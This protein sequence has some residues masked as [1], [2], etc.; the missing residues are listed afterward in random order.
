MAD[1]EYY[2][3]PATNTR[4]VESRYRYVASASQTTFAANYAVGYVDVY[5]NGSH[6]DPGV[7][8]TAA[9][10]ASIVL[11]N[12]A[13]AGAS[14]VIVCRRQV[15]I[16]KNNDTMISNAQYTATAAQ[17]VF[18]LTYT[19]GGVFL[20][21][22]NGISVPFTAADGATVVL[23]AGCLAGDVVV[24]SYHS[25][26]SVANVIAK[27][28]DT[29]AGTLAL[30]AGSTA[31]T[32]TA[33]DS[34]TKIATTAFVNGTALTLTSGTTATTANLFDNSTA[35]AN[36]GFVQAAKGNYA[37]IYPTNV[38]M[39]LTSAQSGMFVYAYGSS[40]VT[41]T[42]PVMSGVPSGTVFTIT[43]LASQT[44]II[45]RTGSDTLTA[46]GGGLT[47]ISVPA[48]STV[49]VTALTAG[50]WSVSGTGTLSY[51]NSFNSNLV[52]NGYQV[53]PTGLIIQWG[54]ATAATSPGTLVT[55]PLTFPTAVRSVTSGGNASGYT[56]TGSETTTNFRL[57]GPAAGCFW[58]SI[59]Y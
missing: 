38:S 49:V 12:G 28:G 27:S 2:G 5:Y 7:A 37:G 18:S 41:F 24:V 10:G 1:T 56:T 39:S 54:N 35:V 11:A 42:L 13:V 17:T 34:T 50:T 51:N 4:D 9:D 46:T 20:V 8:F 14:I 21:T 33:G 22:R 29:M 57:I 36:T 19:T 48:G 53:L 43:N 25:V 47:S 55:F 31:P 30:A 40:V 45:S 16:S 44:A 58:I 59:G 3:V 52:S 23:G 15:Q 26:F 6:L 32:P